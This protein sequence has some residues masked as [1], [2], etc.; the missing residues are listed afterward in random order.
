MLGKLQEPRSLD[1]KVR[2]LQEE[3]NVM[4]GLPR[5]VCFTPPSQKSEFLLFRPAG[6]APVPGYSLPLYQDDDG[7]EAHEFLDEDEETGELKPR[8]TDTLKPVGGAEAEEVWY[9]VVHNPAVMIREQPDEKARMVGRK[10]AGKRL[11]IQSVKDG[12]WLQLHPSELVK[13]AAQEGWVVMDPVEAGLPAGS[14]LLE[15]VSP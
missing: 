13:L 4:M 8:G 6:D 3:I 12:K 7:D 11:R 15:K 5:N 14:P 9:Q 10:K 2:K 1:A